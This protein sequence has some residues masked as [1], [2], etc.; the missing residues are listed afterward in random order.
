MVLPLIPYFARITHVRSHLRTDSMMRVRY[1]P[2]FHC[3]APSMVPSHFPRRRAARDRKST[4]L[5][6]SHQLISYAVFCLKKKQNM[7]VMEEISG[8]REMW[9]ASR[10]REK[11]R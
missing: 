11:T 8:E 6:S 10:N 4:R 1:G 9:A 7:A 5:N 2:F 3:C